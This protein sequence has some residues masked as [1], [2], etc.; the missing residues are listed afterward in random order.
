MLRINLISSPRNIS[1]ALMYSFAQRTDTR[2][3]DEP[4]YGY[5]LH[6]RPAP[7]PGREEIIKT[8]EIDPKKVVK[9]LL[10]GNEMPVLFIKNMA[11]HLIEIEERFFFSVT[12][13]F[14]I[15]DPRQLIASFAQIIS[16][17]TMT[18]IGVKKQHELYTWLKQS[19][20]EPVVLD[21]GELLKN[22]PDVLRKLCTSLHLPFESDMLS[23]SP[24]PRPEDGIW[25][26]DWYQSVHSSTGFVRQ[27]TSN[28]PLPANLGPL[29]E[30]AL[31]YYT[32]MFDASIKA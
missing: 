31:P 4:F 29:H 22:P 24:G 30:E 25:A 19:G 20:Q 1:T 15:R 14:L 18:D 12:N 13:L 8:M 23:W 5:Y 21:S 6:I 32:E 26:R 9:S 16:N 7:H 28:R 2:V 17:P 11:H 10:N 27:E 3:V